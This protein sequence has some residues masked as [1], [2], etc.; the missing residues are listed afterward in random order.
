MKRRRPGTV[1]T[2]N[3][4]GSLHLGK[5]SL[6]LAQ[7]SGIETTGFGEN[8]WTLCGDVML[9][10]MAGLMSAEIAVENSGKIS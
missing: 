9:N 7:A 3:D 1:R 10:M 6:S 2:A 8:R 5:L 4:T